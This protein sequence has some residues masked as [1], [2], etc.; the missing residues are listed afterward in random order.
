ME[1][2][3]KREAEINPRLH[4]TTPAATGDDTQPAPF[5]KWREMVDR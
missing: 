1:R 3:V 5:D 4:L 2:G